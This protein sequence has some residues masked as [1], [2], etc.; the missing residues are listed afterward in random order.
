MLGNNK[1]DFISFVKNTALTVFS[2]DDKEIEAD[3]L[4]LPVKKEIKSSEFIEPNF[5]VT[6]DELLRLKNLK[7]LSNGYYRISL[8]F[9]DISTSENEGYIGIMTTV[10]DKEVNFLSMGNN[11]STIV[12]PLSKNDILSFVVDVVISGSITFSKYVIQIEKVV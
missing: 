7:I 8:N 5:I 4:Y 3:L 2:E 9:E 11:Y 6:S 1:F 10:N 12:I